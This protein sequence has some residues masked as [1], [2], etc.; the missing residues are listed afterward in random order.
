MVSFDYI[1]L[2]LPIRLILFQITSLSNI[3]L[4][5]IYMY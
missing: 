2:F 4:Y 3:R 5:I 1:K